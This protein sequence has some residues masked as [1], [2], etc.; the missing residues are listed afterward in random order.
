V[1]MTS[2]SAHDPNETSN[3]QLCSFFELFLIKP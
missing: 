1:A 3:A 2:R